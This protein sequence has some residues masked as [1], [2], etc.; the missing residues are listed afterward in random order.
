[1]VFFYIFPKG[2]FSKVKIIARPEFE[3]SDSDVEV[4]HIS[5]YATGTG[6]RSSSTVHIAIARKRRLSLFC[7]VSHVSSDQHKLEE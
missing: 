5:H 4:Q 7:K 6:S 1:M 2:I 3:L